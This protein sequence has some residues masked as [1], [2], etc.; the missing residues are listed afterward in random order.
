MHTIRNYLSLV[1][2]SHTLFAM[3]FAITGFFMATHHYG[4]SYTTIQLALV[5]LTMVFARN[6]AMSFNRYVDREWDQKNQR[7][8]QREIPAGIISPTKALWF[9][10]INSVLFIATTY[11]INPLCFYLSPIALAVIIGYSYTKRFTVLSHFILGIGLGIAPIGA[12]LAVSGEF[13][14]LPVILG[15]AVWAWVSGF[16]IIYAL[17]DE[18]FDR[19]HHLFSIPAWVGRKKALIISRIMHA[20]SAI[21]IIYLTT[22]INPNWQIILSAIVFV[23]LLVYQHTQISP[24]NLNNLNYVFFTLNG[25]AS[26]VYAFFTIWGFLAK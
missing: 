8:A 5:V 1:K 3:P 16:D 9:V 13:R 4:Y 23:G 20:I 19:K 6:A 15:F 22:I 14:L 18:D 2:F 26:V 24:T 17:Q 12:F 7:T 25:I 10:I 11:F 21:F